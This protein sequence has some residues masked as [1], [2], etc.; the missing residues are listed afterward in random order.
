MGPSRHPHTVWINFPL[1][2][3]LAIFKWRTLSSNPKK[4]CMYPNYISLH[5]S[6]NK[7]RNGFLTKH[8]HQFCH[9]FPSS[10]TRTLTSNT[11]YV[12][13]DRQGIIWHRRVWNW[14][15]ISYKSRFKGLPSWETDRW[16]ERHGQWWL[17]ATWSR[18]TKALLIGRC[19]T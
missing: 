13:W 14:L 6:T 17:C 7:F 18:I 12:D 9:Y 1:Y 19:Q 15:K 3:K 5:S 11:W 4:R 10:Q 2:F 16:C 8:L